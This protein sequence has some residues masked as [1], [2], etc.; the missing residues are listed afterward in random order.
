MANASAFTEKCN[1]CANV[2]FEFLITGGDNKFTIDANTGD[3]RTSSSPLDREEKGRYQL[4]AV[5]TD[6]GNRQV[7]LAFW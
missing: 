7:C 3:I 4:L 5:A 2:S 1:V 6:R